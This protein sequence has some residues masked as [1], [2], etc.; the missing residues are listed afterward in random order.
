MLNCDRVTTNMAQE[1]PRIGLNFGDAEKRL[2]GVE[3]MVES[4][5]AS[6]LQL[7]NW[8]HN[9]EHPAV[10]STS[11][12]AVEEATVPATEVRRI[13]ANL[14][15][16]SAQVA[17][18]TGQ[19]HHWETMPKPK[20]A[21]V[22]ALELQV[23][24]LMTRLERREHEVH[25][26]R[27][28]IRTRP[29]GGP[30]EGMRSDSHVIGEFERA[31]VSLENKY[32]LLKYAGTPPV[33]LIGIPT[34]TPKREARV[35]VFG[36][37]AR[38]ERVAGSLPG[39][40]YPPAED[41]WSSMRSDDRGFRDRAPRGRRSRT[42]TH[43]GHTR[44]GMGVIG[45]NAP[46]WTSATLRRTVMVGLCR[47]CSFNCSTDKNLSRMESGFRKKSRREFYGQLRLMQFALN[48]FWTPRS[49]G[50]SHNLKE[51]IRG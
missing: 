40:G 44:P 18:L 46:G 36:V 4:H 19:T 34:P 1:I 49:A 26:L 50:K 20:L 39:S 14:K 35:R 15:S 32:Q 33:N 37:P 12:G 6:I 28:E 2:H 29:H 7:V 9:L 27:E 16:T 51:R 8:V 43:E 42:R 41:D 48:D 17:T 30:P 3:A 21:K 11:T 25:A 24:L 13:A 23:R 5:K 10:S 45:G 31:F 22:E 38:E 47:G